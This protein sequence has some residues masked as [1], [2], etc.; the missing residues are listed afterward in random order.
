MISRKKL[1]IRE[2]GKW[3]EIHKYIQDKL[4]FDIC[5]NFKTIYCMGKGEVQ[6]NLIQYMLVGEII[7]STDVNYPVPRTIDENEIVKMSENNLGMYDNYELY[8][9]S[10][11]VVYCL[12][13][14]NNMCIEERLKEEALLLF[15]C[16][17]AILQNS[18]LN[19]INRLIVNEL[20]NDSNISSQE[21]LKLQ[22]KYGKTVL[23]WDNKIYNYYTAQKLSDKITEIFETPKLFNEYKKNKEHI[24]QISAQ[25]NNI[26][27]GRGLIILNIVTFV[28]NIFQLNAMIPNPKKHIP[29]ITSICFFIVIFTVLI[30]NRRKIK[31]LV[32][33]CFSLLIN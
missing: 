5:G 3:I 26:W 9:S 32:R 31:K 23:L 8:A 4:G 10:K 11:N 7:E 27:S 1:R 17:I 14:F 6:K 15:I 29:L 28:L 25:K 24:E 19:R 2:Q 30:R 16:E 33:K 22:V 12:K 18:A 20:L 13:E 21:A